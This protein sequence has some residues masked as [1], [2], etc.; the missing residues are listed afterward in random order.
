[1]IGRLKDLTRSR[2]GQWLI[3]LS[4]PENFS[5]TY[6]ELSDKDVSF[7][8]KAA[9]RHRS[10]SANAYAWVLI[11]KIAEKTGVK[12]SEVYRNGIREIGGVSTC[13]G[14]KD[15]AIPV[16]RESWEKGHLGRQVEVIPGSAKEGWSNVKI[17]FGSSEFD[18]SQMARLIDSLIQDAESL[19]IPTIT[20]EQAEKLIGKWAVKNDQ[21]HHAG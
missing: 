13:V 20:D 18:S 8:I 16:F 19:G 4:T 5:D 11:D 1:M 21:K 7:D 9:K 6:D 3:T 12:V 2:D 17:Y 15:E 10:L 14:M